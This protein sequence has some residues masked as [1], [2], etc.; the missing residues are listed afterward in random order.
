MSDK[1]KMTR[2]MEI[3]E[4]SYDV[5]IQEAW[6]K[7]A[8]LE[9]EIDALAA[10]LLQEFGGPTQNESACE[11]SVRML[12]EQKAEIAEVKE[13]LAHYQTVIETP[14][15]EVY[16]KTYVGGRGLVKKEEL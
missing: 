7:I 15:P 3:E 2:Q 8:S 9:A 5:A 1:E 12:R 6:Q 11:M 16:E 4:A 10:V 13:A 14:P